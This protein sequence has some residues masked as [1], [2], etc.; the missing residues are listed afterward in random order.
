MDGESI[1]FFEDLARITAMLKAIT[2]A[3]ASKGDCQFDGKL[4]VVSGPDEFGGKLVGW[5][6]P[7]DDTWAFVP[8]LPPALLVP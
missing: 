2:K 4:E 5:I 8:C 6:Q 1:I 7:Y 3:D